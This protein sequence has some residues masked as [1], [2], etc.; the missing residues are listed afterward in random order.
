M[1]SPLRMVV[2]TSSILISLWASLI[3]MWFVQ[4]NLFEEQS[5]LIKF[6][7]IHLPF[8]FFIFPPSSSVI[9]ETDK[10]SFLKESKHSSKLTIIFGCGRNFIHYQ[11]Q[12][13]RFLCNWNIRI[14]FIYRY[15]DIFP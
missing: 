1:I 14:L 11:A 9:F 6:K 8:P 7:I 4:R 15:Q 2:C 10:P 13:M 12:A 5:C 3:N